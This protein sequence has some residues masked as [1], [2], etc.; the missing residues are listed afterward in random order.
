MLGVGGCN[1]DA[2]TFPPFRSFKLSGRFSNK[3]NLKRRS[4]A[5]NLNALPIVNVIAHFAV[6]SG[7]GNTYFNDRR[8]VQNE[9]NIN[10]YGPRL[11]P[12]ICQ[13]LDPHYF[14]LGTT[15]KADFRIWRLFIQRLR[16]SGDSVNKTKTT[17]FLRILPLMILK[18]SFIDSGR[19]KQN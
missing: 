15:Y 18:V 11:L 17:F 12:N 5:N 6:T 7:N 2:T 13:H 14:S 16:N 19:E 9:I 8:H 1:Y 10:R 3:I 4:A